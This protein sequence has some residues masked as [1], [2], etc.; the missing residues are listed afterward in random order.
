MKH[1]L[2]LLI[3][4]LLTAALLGPALPAGAQQK[5]AMNIGLAAR[6]AWPQADLEPLDPA[7]SYG[8]VFHYWL[9]TTTSVDV[10]LDRF[11]LTRAIDAPGGDADL[12]FELWDLTVGL[13]YRPKLDLLVRPYA[14]VGVGYEFWTLKLDV[15]GY[16]NRSGGSMVYYAG[17]G[18]DWEFIEDWSLT[19]GARYYYVPLA[20]KLENEV[21]S[22]TAGDIQVSEDDLVSAGLLTAGIELTWRFR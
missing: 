11:A 22:V 12:D 6:Y 2:R 9:T 3:A 14:E 8:I 13:R 1:P 15:D 5:S 10:G 4:A 7:L 16:E 20:E 19:T 18:Y 17:I 21:L